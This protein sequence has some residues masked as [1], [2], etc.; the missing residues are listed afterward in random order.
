MKN[1]LFLC[2]ALYLVSIDSVFSQP[3]SK[4][5]IL[6]TIDTFLNYPPAF[7]SKDDSLLRPVLVQKGFI[8]TSLKEKEATKI[9]IVTELSRLVFRL[10]KGDMVIFHFS[11]HGISVPDTNGDETDALDEVIVPYNGNKLLNFQSVE[12]ADSLITDDELYLYLKHISDAIGPEGHLLVS[13][14]ACHAGTV[15][16]SSGGLH[17]GVG[18]HPST[19]TPNEEAYKLG[20]ST[21]EN[22]FAIYAAAPDE[23]NYATYLNAQPVGALTLA[24]SQSL[25]A[26]QPG[27]SYGDLFDRICRII[28]KN[29]LQQHPQ[30]EGN[31][32][33]G[34]FNSNFRA[35][36]NYFSVERMF[37]D[38]LQLNA[39]TVSGVYPGA[40]FAFYAP[41]VQDTAGI[42]PLATGTVNNVG[43]LRSE[44]VLNGPRA[45]RDALL[46]SRACLR[47]RSYGT[48]TL[49]VYIPEVVY[50]TYPALKAHL[51][52]YSAI[53]LQ[54]N[55][56]NNH[57]LALSVEKDS[58]FICTPGGLP[59][60]G[61]PKSQVDSR[62][63]SISNRLLDWMQVDFLRAETFGDANGLLRFSFDIIPVET[64]L[65]AGNQK[66]VKE[67]TPVSITRDQ[68]NQ[69][70][71]TLNTTFKI[72]VKNI[73]KVAAYFTVIEFS[74]IGDAV[75]L[76]PPKSMA[77]QP[78]E[79]RLE[80][81]QSW[82]SDQI[83]KYWDMKPPVGHEIFK[84]IATEQC[85]N[86]R[87]AFESPGRGAKEVIAGVFSY[88]IPV[89]IKK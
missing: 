79:F 2:A 6:V 25:T 13:I 65:V 58:L 63:P 51:S 75:F 4:Y 7:A 64:K 61:L 32:K 69:H 16:R 30:A 50:A 59:V 15:I 23:N 87:D 27:E 47:D 9:N 22:L 85:V 77:T 39:G 45:S 71:I 88:A 67:N 11:G 81:G 76:I 17:R 86:L 43:L 55:D 70:F 31:A 89:I 26:L 29:N 21:I 54:D 35:S 82:D 72:R 53:R 14:D 37:A 18:T 34:V 24:L 20:N 52:N 62:L 19:T 38:T 83:G 66:T 5:A 44:I 42:T 1:Y 78:C 36:P 84:L 60:W 57:H 80:S 33:R 10:K 48:L 68:N 40:L 12:A 41:S 49:K 56:N 73:G 74:P 8:V 46:E 28:L 3:V